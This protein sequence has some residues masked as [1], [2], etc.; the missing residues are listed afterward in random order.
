MT[1]TSVSAPAFSKRFAVS[2]S[3]L[4]PGNTGIRT[5]GFETFILH[6]FTFSAS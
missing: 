3:Q 5:L 1:N 2:Y 6:D 4:V